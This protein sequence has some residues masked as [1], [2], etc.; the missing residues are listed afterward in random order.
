MKLRIFLIFTFI[1]GS[2]FHTNAQPKLVESI[3]QIWL[4]D[5]TKWRNSG[6]S[7]YEYDGDLLISELSQ[8]WFTARS[9]WGNAKG[10][11]YFYDE[12]GQLELTLGETNIYDDDDNLI[13][14]TGIPYT[15]NNEEKL[16]GKEYQMRLSQAIFDCNDFGLNTI[17]A[18]LTIDGQEIRQAINLT[19]VN[20][21]DLEF[22]EKTMYI[23][24]F[25]T[26]NNTGVSMENG[27]VDLNQAINVLPCRIANVDQVYIRH[28]DYFAFSEEVDYSTFSGG[29]ALSTFNKIYVT[30]DMVFESVGGVSTLKLSNFFIEDGVTATFRNIDF[31]NS[32]IIA[33]KNS[34][35]ILENCNFFA[36][37]FAIVSVGSVEAYNTTFVILKEGL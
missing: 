1:F 12:N 36:N 31:T 34:K 11:D 7:V 18:I 14:T 27:F 30:K 25:A 22:T 8:H 32:T 15:I 17:E 33:G 2:F 23:N 35:V 20:N 21:P 13:E 28:G 6:R 3:E 19:V 26:G 5:S 29:D 4:A 9:D 37:Q 10:A 24:K 16:C